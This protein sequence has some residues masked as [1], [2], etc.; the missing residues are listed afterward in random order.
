M[1]FFRADTVTVASGGRIE[2]SG[3]GYRGGPG[4]SDYQEGYQGESIRGLGEIGAQGGGTNE[5]NDGGGGVNI[6]GAGIRP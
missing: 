4:G 1:I 2:A 6:D 5:P 3:L